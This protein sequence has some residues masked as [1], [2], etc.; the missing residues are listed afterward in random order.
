M[1]AGWGILLIALA[2]LAAMVLVGFGVAAVVQRVRD[3]WGGSFAR[4]ASFAVRSRAGTM[5]IIYLCQ[6]TKGQARSIVRFLDMLLINV[7]TL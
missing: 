5:P 1:H 4:C 2:C 6:F 3:Y 7:S